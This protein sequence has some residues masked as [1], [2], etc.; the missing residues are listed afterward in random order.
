[1]GTSTLSVRSRPRTG[2]VT[3]LGGVRRVRCSAAPWT[4]RRW[5]RMTRPHDARGRACLGGVALGRIAH[6]VGAHEGVGAEHDR[7]G[8][9]PDRELAAEHPAHLH[10]RTGPSAVDQQP[11]G[12]HAGDHGGGAGRGHDPPLRGDLL[13]GDRRAPACGGDGLLDGLHRPGGHRDPEA[14]Q[15]P[16]EQQPTE[17]DLADLAPRTV[18]GRA[19]HGHEDAGPLRRV[20]RPAGHGRGDAAGAS[21][22]GA[23]PD[24]VGL[25]AISAVAI[26]SS[27]VRQVHHRAHGP[28]MHAVRRVADGAHGAAG[29]AHSARCQERCGM[30]APSGITPRRPAW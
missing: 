20:D 13:R 18:A 23:S 15:G 22:G 25:A 28:D 4:A 8:R 6:A 30:I 27:S 10:R 5:P 17:R 12:D 16:G 1:M 14:G 7:T 21:L 11:L 26:G 29:P 2:R 9:T 19:A 3:E 24:A